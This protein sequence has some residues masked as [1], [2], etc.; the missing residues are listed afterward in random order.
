MMQYR[1]DCVTAINTFIG[2]VK[3]ELVARVLRKVLKLAVEH[4]QGRL[5]HLDSELASKLPRRT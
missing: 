2:Q 5:P 4:K 1:A 3:I